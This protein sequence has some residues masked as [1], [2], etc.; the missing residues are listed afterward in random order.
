VVARAADPGRTRAG[1]VEARSSSQHAGQITALC[2]RQLAIHIRKAARTLG[3]W[4]R[5]SSL[6]GFAEVLHGYG[7]KAPQCFKRD[8]AE[9]VTRAVVVREI[10]PAL[11]DVVER[12]DM[13]GGARSR[14]NVRISE[15]V[16]EG[17]VRMNM[18]G[19]RRRLQ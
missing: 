8:R 19:S 18:A 12:R 6:G 13:A 14:A 9:R 3:P 7:A 1:G 17:D 4:L 16:Y 10:V 2:H 5:E 11:V 15:R